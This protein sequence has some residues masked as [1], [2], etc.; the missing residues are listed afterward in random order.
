MQ[1]KNFTDIPNATLHR[2]IDFVDPGLAKNVRVVCKSSRC[3]SHGVSKRQKKEVVVWIPNNKSYPYFRDHDHNYRWIKSDSAFPIDQNV[4]TV[5]RE[6]EFHNTQ[7]KLIKHKKTKTGYIS[8]LILNKEEDILML[9]AH[10][11]R[12]QWQRRRPP[13]NEWAYGCQ[14]NKIKFAVERDA[15]V[16]DMKKLREW[17]RLASPKQVYPEVPW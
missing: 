7:Y 6:Q 11:L 5:L 3:I 14:G 17:R 10:E 9:L 2:M 1:L 4:D 12:P 13:K 8:C 15:S 16:Y